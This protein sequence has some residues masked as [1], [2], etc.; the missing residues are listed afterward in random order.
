MDSLVSNPR[1][2]ITKSQESCDSQTPGWQILLRFREARGNKCRLWKATQGASQP[3]PLQN[4]ESSTVVSAAGGARWEPAAEHASARPAAEGCVAEINVS[5]LR[6]KPG[7]RHSQ[8]L[9]WQETDE[10]LQHPKNLLHQISDKFAPVRQLV[11]VGKT[12]VTL[13]SDFSLCPHLPK[14]YSFWQGISPPLPC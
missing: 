9:L 5:Q 3:Y 10:K 11:V 6:C 1:F 4:D 14:F 13:T 8:W 12:A 2:T 7:P